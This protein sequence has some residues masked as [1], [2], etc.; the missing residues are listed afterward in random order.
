MADAADVDDF[1]G[2]SHLSRMDRKTFACHRKPAQF[3]TRQRFSLPIRPRV[4]EALE[5]SI[6]IKNRMAV[7]AKCLSSVPVVLHAGFNDKLQHMQLNTAI[8]KEE[9]Q[10]Q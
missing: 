7:S 9:H 10:R 1:G 2:T 4:A 5:L 3:V 8:I 6:S